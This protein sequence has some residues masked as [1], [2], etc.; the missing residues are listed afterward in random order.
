MGPKNKIQKNDA[1]YC[2]KCKGHGKVESDRTAKC[3]EDWKEPKDQECDNMPFCDP[4]QGQHE[5]GDCQATLKLQIPTHGI[6]KTC[7]HANG[8]DNSKDCPIGNGKKPAHLKQWTQKKQ[9]EW[10]KAKASKS[11]V[12]QDSGQPSAS[13]Q[14]QSSNASQPSGSKQEEGPKEDD[15]YD[16]SQPDSFRKFWCSKCKRQVD[17][18]H[19]S[20]CDKDCKFKFHGEQQCDNYPYCIRSGDSQHEVKDCPVPNAPG[21]YGANTEIC[22]RCGHRNSHKDGKCNIG[23]GKNP[24]HLK[25][26]TKSK[27]DDWQAKHTGI[28]ATA[29]QDQ[30][31]LNKK[32]RAMQIT[33]KPAPDGP[34]ILTKRQ[35]EKLRARSNL[36]LTPAQ[37][38]SEGTRNHVLDANFLSVKIS[39]NGPDI[40][41][42]RIEL[43]KI[44]GKTPSKRETRRALIEQ[45]LAQRPPGTE[46]ATDYFSYIV[47]VGKLYSEFNDDALAA[48]DAYSVRHIR[49]GRPGDLY[50]VVDTYVHYE[51]RFDVAGL[52]N[53]IDPNS[54]RDPN[55]FP[56][57][58]LRILNIISWGKILH[59]QFQG[60]RVGNKFF[61]DEQ[62]EK[63]SGQLFE[64]GSLV[65]NIRTGFFTSMRP[66]INKLL[67][68][69]NS[70]TSAFYAP[71][72][73]Q[74][75]LFARGGMKG[76]KKLE[77]LSYELKN[78][79]RVTFEGDKG[80]VTGK[81]RVVRLIDPTRF[82]S[83]VEFDK[84][85]NSNNPDGATFK[86]SVHK[87]MEDRKPLHTF[88]LPPGIV[89]QVTC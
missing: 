64:G 21:K 7:G 78:K 20:K 68:N 70:A 15:V 72:N 38:V 42:Y 8:H 65:Y 51:G 80:A 47:S 37:T 46:Y 22:T 66:G 63:Y 73:F 1:Y 88:P 40:R 35:D 29:V 77:Q 53:Y 48:T 43:G 31:E 56:D 69:V 27:W 30:A 26:W 24:E 59:T 12:S 67:L 5:V 76:R 50:P 52:R 36:Q 11:A 86:C 60:G 39:N 13:N 61:P 71:G 87:H 58:D 23:D 4:K 89:V 49:S 81:K 55:Y 74:H 79:I 9:D 57:E 84:P 45:L 28:R 34:E 41:K 17:V 32:I 3:F 44:N 82:V 25:Q 14:N 6:C 19:R 62:R 2:S 83:D 54:A 18:N 75:W 10:K 85:V 16:E 33:V